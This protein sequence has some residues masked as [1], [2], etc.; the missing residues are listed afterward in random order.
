MSGL[1]VRLA[2]RL[3]EEEPVL[4]R[5]F[6][7]AMLDRDTNT[8]ILPTYRLPPGWSHAATDVLFQIPDNYP[9]GCPDNVCVEADLRLTGGHMPTNDM[10]VHVYLGREWLQLSW[11]LEPSDW[12]PTNDPSTG[13]NLASYLAGAL[14]RLHDPS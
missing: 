4:L 14:A 6:P 9:A 5:D 12:T 3:D 11:H 7:K 13:S 10:G 2:E 8:V 1:R